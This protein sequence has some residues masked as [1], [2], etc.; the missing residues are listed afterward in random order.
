MKEWYARECEY[1]TQDAA[2]ACRDSICRAA[3][4]GEPHLDGCPAIQSEEIQD[5][6]C[7]PAGLEL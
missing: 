6:T 1:C 4:L 7:I 2:L 3:G 5:C